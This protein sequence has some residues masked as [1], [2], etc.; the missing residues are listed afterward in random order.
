VSGAG[1]IRERVDKPEMTARPGMV[2]ATF[3]DGPVTARLTAWMA[4]VLVAATTLL[5]MIASRQFEETT[6]SLR[7]TRFNSVVSRV[8]TA[9]EANLSL[10]LP[11]EGLRSVPALLREEWARD[12]TI[13]SIDV[14]EDS[15]RLLYTTDRGGSGANVPDEWLTAGAAAGSDIW[16]RSGNDGVVVGAPLTTTFGKRVGGVALRCGEG[17]AAVSGGTAA[18]FAPRLSPILGIAIAALALAIHLA[19]RPLNRRL[20]GLA[21]AVGDPGA[22]GGVDAGENDRDGLGGTTADFIEFGSEVRRGIRDV[23]AEIRRI[24]D[25]GF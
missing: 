14:F 25:D 12:R 10:G 15:G 16:V 11:L 13:L 3:G 24:D 17:S 1:E 9:V 18:D 6:R 5:L 19:L 22:P 2:N 23:R 4:L 8:K 20:G 7:D 21:M